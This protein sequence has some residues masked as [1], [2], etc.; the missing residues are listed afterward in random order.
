VN[1]HI[2]SAWTVAGGYAYQD[3]F[4][5]SATVAARAGAQVGQVP[6]HTFSLWNN[7]RIHPNVGVGLGVTRRS[8]MFAAIDNT[9]T[10]PGYTRADAAAYFT[11]RKGVRVQANVENVFDRKYFLNAD[12]NTNISPGFPRTLRV[13]LTTAF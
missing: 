4:V 8:D 6:H 13:A 1:G 7:Y 3:A 5:T 10:L 12:S 2:T 9:V 11:L